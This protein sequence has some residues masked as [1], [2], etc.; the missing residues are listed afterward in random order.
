MSFLKIFT[1]FALIGDWY[2]KAM[3]DGVVTI[4]EGAQLLIELAGVIGLTV[5]PEVTAL[6]AEVAKDNLEG[7][8]AVVAEGPEVEV[9][10]ETANR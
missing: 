8:E 2:K 3:A 4:A 6:V 1:I 7:Q 5:A 10:D 9:I